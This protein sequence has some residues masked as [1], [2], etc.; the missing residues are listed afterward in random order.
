MEKSTIIFICIFFII[1]A[2]ALLRYYPGSLSYGILWIAFVCLIMICI[3]GLKEK[4][5]GFFGYTDTVLI[6]VICWATA[7]FSWCVLRH[8][9]NPF[10]TLAFVTQ[11]IFLVLLI[12]MVGRGRDEESMPHELT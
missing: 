12:L 5:I 7:L 1:F 10:S 11:G 3:M 8:Y 2:G 4:E 9:E 6:L